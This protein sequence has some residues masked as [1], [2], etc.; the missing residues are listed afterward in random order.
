MFGIFYQ[1]LR[2][3]SFYTVFS[4]DRLLLWLCNDLSIFGCS[5]KVLVWHLFLGR[6]D[7]RFILACEFAISIRCLRPLSS[8]CSA[9]THVQNDRLG[10]I[11]QRS[12]FSAAGPPSKESLW[13][14]LFFHWPLLKSRGHMHERP[15]VRICVMM[16]NNRL[17]SVQVASGLLSLQNASFIVIWRVYVR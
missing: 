2:E 6:T 10:I 7:L 1:F 5:V 11:I 12:Q 3:N 16:N 13:F 14:L 9:L 17:V 8:S 4:A 15:C